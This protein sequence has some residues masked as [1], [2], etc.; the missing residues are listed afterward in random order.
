M[1][2]SGNLPAPMMKRIGDDILCD[3]D[4]DP[5]AGKPFPIPS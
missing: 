3:K 5:F 2:N 1:A 4:H